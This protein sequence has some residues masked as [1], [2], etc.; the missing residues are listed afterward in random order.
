MSTAKNKVKFNLKN[1]HY[2][3]MTSS[4]DSS[5]SYSTPVA[6]PGAVS[7]SMDASGE[8]YRLLITPDHPTPIRCRTHTSSAVPYILY[9]STKEA[10]SLR[11]YSEKEAAATGIYEPEGYKLLEKF[12]KK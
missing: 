9:D 8:P 10:K 2:A 1:V 6:I 11:R 3:I 4:D 5:A 12:L 7:L